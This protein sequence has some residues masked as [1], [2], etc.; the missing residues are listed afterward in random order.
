MTFEYTLEDNIFQLH[1]ELSSGNYHHGNYQQ[2]RITDP[3]SRLISKSSVRDRLLHRAIYR[4]LYPAW[5]KIFIYNSYS[6][7]NNKGTHKAFTKLA[8]V[9]RKISKNYT[10]PCFALK[11]DIR[12]F[13]NSVDHKVL[14]DL[15]KERIEDERLLELLQD[16]IQSFPIFRHAEFISA[17]PVE[18]LKPQQSRGRRVPA[19]AK[20]LWRAS[21]DD[22]EGKG[23]PL[24]NLTSQLFANIYLDPLDKFA[25]HKLKAK[26]YLRYADDFI[27]LSD[28][29]DILMGYLVE[30]NQFLKTKL[31]LNIHPNKIIF[32]KLN[33]GIDYVGYVALPYY[34]IPRRKTVNRIFKKVARLLQENDYEK[35]TKAIPS[36]FGYLSHVN[37][38]KLQDSL[39]KE[40]Q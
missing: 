28:N 32:R 8:D 19:V 40:L 2:F 37:A 23:M 9:S 13:F 34:A 25:K 27:F 12:K 17:S 33:W 38:H 26:H 24:G 29:P 31:K 16:I 20:R 6:C 30:V 10:K 15:L 36:Y 18:I 22:A 11:L 4:V 3:K 14:I 35:L 21:R 5:D 39:L 1:Q 7:R